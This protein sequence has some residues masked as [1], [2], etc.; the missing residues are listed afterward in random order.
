MREHALAGWWGI[1][2]QG[3]HYWENTQPLVL[4]M[5]LFFQREVP[6]G[7]HAGVEQLFRTYEGPVVVFDDEVALRSEVKPKVKEWSN[8]HPRYFIRTDVA[9]SHCPAVCT[10]RLASFLKSFDDH[11]TLNLIGGQWAGNHESSINC[12][13]LGSLDY[14]LMFRRFETRLIPGLYFGKPSRVR[15]TSPIGRTD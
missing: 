13:C 12:G 5:H 3:E 11:E 14:E 15:V 7:Y 2:I 9:S 4:A 10:T 6:E 1:R 8:G